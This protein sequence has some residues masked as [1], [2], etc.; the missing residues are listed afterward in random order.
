MGILVDEESRNITFLYKLQPGKSNGSFGMHVASM[1]GVPKEIVDNAEVA[2]KTHEHT[3]RLKKVH[4]SQESIIPLGLESDFS[5]IDQKKPLERTC[6]V[7]NENVKKTALKTIF[8]LIDG[9]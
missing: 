1:C 9:I 3:S 2:A 8:E 6:A 4:Q 5:W 7:Y